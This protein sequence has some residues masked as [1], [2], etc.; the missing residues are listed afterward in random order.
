MAIKDFKRCPHCGS[1]LGYYQRCRMKGSYHD[2][3]LFGTNEPYNSEMMDGITDT[4]RSAWYYC[5]E[6]DKKLCKV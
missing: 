2:N 6:C 4:F 1:N 5:I 3:K